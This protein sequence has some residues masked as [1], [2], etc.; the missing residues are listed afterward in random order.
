MTDYAAPIPILRSFDEAKAKAFYCEFLGFRVDWE[1]RFGAG[2]PLYFQVSL[3]ACV[4]HLSEHHGDATPGSALRIEVEDVEAL[5]AAL[6]AKNYGNARPGVEKQ[7]W[8]MAECR[9]IDPFGNRLVFC[10]PLES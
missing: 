9:V 7:P 1:H 5:A 6:R 2:L 4:L 8:G 3:G 10:Q